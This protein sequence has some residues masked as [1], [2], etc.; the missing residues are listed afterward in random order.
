MRRK[1][2][3]LRQGGEVQEVRALGRVE[4]KVAQKRRYLDTFA[5]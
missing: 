2:Q 4:A 3:A 5:M 1:P